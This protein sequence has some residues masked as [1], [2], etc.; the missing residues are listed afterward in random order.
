[1]KIFWSVW[2]LNNDGFFFFFGEGDDFALLSVLLWLCFANLVSENFAV[3]DFHKQQSGRQIFRSILFRYL[4]GYLF[5]YH[6]CL[7]NH[8]SFNVLMLIRKMILFLSCQYSWVF[9][10]P[11]KK[12]ITF[13]SFFSSPVI[14]FC[15]SRHFLFYATFFSRF[16]FIKLFFLCLNLFLFYSTA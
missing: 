2:V 7:A 4:T 13:F 9:F 15:F 11:K 14:I 10:E 8:F 6:S 1:M 5:I 16:C 3:V 12:I